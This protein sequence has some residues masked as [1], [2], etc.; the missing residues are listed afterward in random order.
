MYIVLTISEAAY[1][2]HHGHFDD[3]SKHV[4]NEGVESLVGQHSPG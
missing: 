4:V 2:V 3:K 1:S